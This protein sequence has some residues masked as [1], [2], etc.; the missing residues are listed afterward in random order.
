MVNIIIDKEISLDEVNNQESLEESIQKVLNARKKVKKMMSQG[1]VDIIFAALEKANDN[2]LT[3]RGV[4]QKYSLD[5][6][7]IEKVL[8]I[9]G[10][11]F[12]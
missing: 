5:P 9:P 4:A 1:E 2:N 3:C 7:K 11:L 6:S 10:S 12:N 8:P